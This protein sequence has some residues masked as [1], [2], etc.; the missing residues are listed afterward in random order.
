MVLHWLFL[1]RNWLLLYNKRI[2]SFFLVFDSFFV[3]LS[4]FF[5]FREKIKFILILSSLF[6]FFCI[7]SAEFFIFPFFFLIFSTFS[8][9]ENT[10][11]YKQLIRFL[12][13]LVLFIFSLKKRYFLE[14]GCQVI[15]LYISSLI[16]TEIFIFAWKN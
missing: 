11:K 9:N 2:F 12:W 15:I 14:K 13:F 16:L 8:Q 10:I 6:L 3:F 1:N 7:K 5:L 4:E